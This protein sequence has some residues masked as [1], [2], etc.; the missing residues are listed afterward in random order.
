MR[1]KAGARQSCRSGASRHVFLRTLRVSVFDRE[2][3]ASEPWLGAGRDRF[4]AKTQSTQR[5][6]EESR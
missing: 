4:D 2:A 3:H 5:R 1:W 6:A